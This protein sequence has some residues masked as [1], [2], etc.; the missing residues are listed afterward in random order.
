MRVIL[1]SSTYVGNDL[2]H[3]FVG[4]GSHGEA[5]LCKERSNELTK[6]VFH[7][8]Q[9]VQQA[10]CVA[11]P[12]GLGISCFKEVGDNH[13]YLQQV[14][15]QA[16]YKFNINDMKQQGMIHQKGSLRG[17]LPQHGLVYSEKVKGSYILKMVESGLTLIP[18]SSRKWKSGYLSVCSTGDSCITVE[19]MDKVLDVFNSKGKIVVA[20]EC[21]HGERSLFSLFAYIVLNRPQ[22]YS[23]CSSDN[24]F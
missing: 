23:K 1:A 17:Y 3:P 16:T 24:L 6:Y 7:N 18:P 15:D 22:K 5:V 2:A 13:V 8:H 14:R 9:H 4:L 21:H 19:G 11:L 10:A 20:C 12:E